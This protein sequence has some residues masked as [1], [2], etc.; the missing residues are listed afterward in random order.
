MWLF[1]ADLKNPEIVTLRNLSQESSGVYRCTASNDVGE[2]NC[3]IEVTM[4]CE[5]TCVRLPTAVCGRRRE[6]R[7]R[8]GEDGRLMCCYYYVLVRERLFIAVYNLFHGR[9]MTVTI[10][11]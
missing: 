11:G 8:M 7:G 10:N 1:V 6:R 4:Q 3:I 2:E 9:S 5:W